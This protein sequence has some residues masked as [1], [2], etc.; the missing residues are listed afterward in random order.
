VV[1]SV[2]GRMQEPIIPGFSHA[3]RRAPLNAPSV[4]ETDRDAK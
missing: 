3:A 2:R 1:A 4:D